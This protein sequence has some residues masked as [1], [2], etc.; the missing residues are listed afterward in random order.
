MPGLASPP[1]ALAQ[2]VLIGVIESSSMLRPEEAPL[3]Y[4]SAP[5]AV[6]EDLQRAQARL[7]EHLASPGCW[8]SGAERLAIAEESRRADR[9]GPCRE[10]KAALS[11]AAVAGGH[12]AGADLPAPLVDVIHRVRTDPGRLSRRW[13]DGVRAA[14]LDEGRYV[15]AI[16]IVALLAGADWFCRALGIPPH[17]LPEAKPG[18]PSGHRPRGLSDQG[19]WV[20]MLAPADASGPEADLYGGASFVP[21]VLRALS[22]VP[23]HVRTLV[24]SSEAHYLPAGGLVDPSARRHLDRMQIELVAARV[25]ALNECFY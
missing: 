18:A 23:G 22:S 11:P 7:L 25:S 24:A 16:G 19:A 15:E 6:R 20:P 8:F 2:A 12:D 13:F 21:N 10:R 3:D 1:D 17:R 5:V 14:G 4:S 9:C